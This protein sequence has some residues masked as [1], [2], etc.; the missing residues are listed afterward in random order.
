M[1]V[2]YKCSNCGTVIYKFMRAG[3]DY[4]GVP[5]PSELMIRVRSTCPNCGKSLSNNIELNHITITL[6]K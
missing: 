4:Y 6:R 2:I 5:S 3:Q 1:P